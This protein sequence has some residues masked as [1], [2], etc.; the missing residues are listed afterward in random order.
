[1]E[2][3][4]HARH[5]E[6]SDRVREHVDRK[7]GRLDRYLPDLR[8]AR[9]DLVHGTKRSRGEVYTAQVTAYVNGGVLRAE[10]M[11]QDV[12]AAIDLASDK[13]HRQI[14]RY[15]GKR[16]DRWHDHERPELPPE[17]D[18]TADEDGAQP[19]VLRRK[20]FPLHEMDEWEAIE[21]LNLVD[22]DFFVYV[23]GAT[24]LVNVLYRRKDGGYGLI[25]PI[26]A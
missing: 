5:V 14:E 16:L 9:V 2:I 20:R 4:L 8:G 3:E 23:N 22:H 13:L 21:Q 15:R 26:L 18:D 25:D 6:L 24:G 11:D 1:M 19:K 12:Y 17:I 10:E 7:I